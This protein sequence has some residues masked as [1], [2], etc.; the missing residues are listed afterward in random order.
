MLGVINDLISNGI[1]TI[2]RFY[3]VNITQIDYWFVGEMFGCDVFLIGYNIDRELFLK[4]IDNEDL[5]YKLIGIFS[6]CYR[7]D[8]LETTNYNRREEICMHIG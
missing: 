8:M 1:S 3:K 5:Y 6:L 7:K 2:S 4:K